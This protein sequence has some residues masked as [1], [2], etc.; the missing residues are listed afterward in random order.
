MLMLV[1]AFIVLE[2]TLEDIWSNLSE[3][4]FGVDV[5]T[6]GEVLFVG[7][8]FFVFFFAVTV[9]PGGTEEGILLE[10]GDGAFGILLSTAFEEL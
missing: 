7:E 4:V 1:N 3:V 8:E 2:F 9:A 10:A 6:E 5:G